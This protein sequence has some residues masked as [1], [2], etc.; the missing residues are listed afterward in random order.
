MGVDPIWLTSGL[1]RPPKFEILNAKVC[2]VASLKGLTKKSSDLK[3]A[4]LYDLQLRSWK[5]QWF[6]G[7]PSKT[8][9]NKWNINKSS[10]IYLQNFERDVIGKRIYI[11]I[12]CQKNHSFRF[13]RGT[14][15]TT[16]FSTSGTH[17]CCPE[18]E[19]HGCGLW[20]LTFQKSHHK[21]Y[22]PF[23]LIFQCW[24]NSGCPYWF[25]LHLE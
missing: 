15:K 20:I 10:K 13:S 9:R 1:L 6:L 2:L 23:H 25:D 22:L 12:Y 21:P 19:K 8:A 14:P 7:R 24:C 4:A 16:C 18:V 17:V 5:S 3:I 11:C